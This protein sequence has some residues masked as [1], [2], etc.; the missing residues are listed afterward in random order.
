M[1]IAFDTPSALYLN[2]L[3]NKYCKIGHKKLE[4]KM[5]KGIEN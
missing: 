1:R 2:V 4:L 3:Q 5:S